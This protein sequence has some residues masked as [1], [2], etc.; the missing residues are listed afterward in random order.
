MPTTHHTN[1]A[2]GC[3]SFPQ[4]S[5]RDADASS[6][7]SVPST[8]TEAADAL[9]EVRSHQT[10]PEVAALRSAGFR[11]LLEH[12]QPVTPEQLA[13]EAG[14]SEIQVTDLLA[15][16]LRGRV[17]LDDDGNLL[18]LAGL[19]VAP[20]HHQ[21]TIDAKTR[22]TWC[23]LDAVGILAALEATGT[24]QST[25]PNTGQGINIAFTNGQ[26]DSDAVLFILGGYD[27]GNVREDWC[28]LVNFFSSTEDARAWVSENQ[29]EG[30]VVSVTDITEE[31]AAMWRPVTDHTSPQAE[32]RKD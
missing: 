19:T 5:D 30:D 22:W 2:A 18:G 24:I 12:G 28:P 6:C 7:C 14:L 26:P 29:L 3:C 25:H 1:D 10:P 8:Q 4:S 13:A 11:L 16:D 27:G 17:E 31:A 9:D 21:L 23:A 15:T 32:T 20:T